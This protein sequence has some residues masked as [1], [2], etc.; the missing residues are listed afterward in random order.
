[1]GV[2]AEG[3][4]Y[5]LQQGGKSAADKFR[6]KLIESVKYCFK[7]KDVL[8]NRHD[9]A[10]KMKEAVEEAKKNYPN[11][12]YIDKPGAEKEDLVFISID[13]LKERGNM[14]KIDGTLRD[15][16]LKFF[17]PHCRE[18]HVQAAISVNTNEQGENEFY[19]FFEGKDAA[20]IDMCLEQ[21]IKDYERDIASKQKDANKREPQ[22]ITD[23]K[24]SHRELNEKA[25][26]IKDADAKNESDRHQPSEPTRELN[27]SDKAENSRDKQREFDPDITDKSKKET[28]ENKG[29]RGKVRGYKKRER[30]K[31]FL[32]AV[33]GSLLKA[34]D[35]KIAVANSNEEL[36]KESKEKTKTHEPISR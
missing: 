33:G 34:L 6:N 9:F 4:E 10:K 31:G 36:A 17:E 24:E 16:M 22:E 35:H 32:D 20:I 19:V 2:I 23:D 27:A 5:E 7:L 12:P 18:N 3:L 15:E 11:W 29:K 25:K 30:T 1:M 13:E 8:A 21:G 26:A 28:R 14:K